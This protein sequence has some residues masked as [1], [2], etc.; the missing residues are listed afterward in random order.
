MRWLLELLWIQVAGGE[1]KLGREIL[2]EPGIGR[3]S[4]NLVVQNA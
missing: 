4:Q 2:W 1:R 3:A